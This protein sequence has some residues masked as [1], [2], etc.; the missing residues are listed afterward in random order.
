MFKLFENIFISVYLTERN[1]DIEISILDSMGRLII[2]EIVFEREIISKKN[3]TD[4]PSPTCFYAVS[5]ASV[6]L[7]RGGI[8]KN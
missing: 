4:K 2:S 7:K 3:F 5:D 6:I 1:F 8:N